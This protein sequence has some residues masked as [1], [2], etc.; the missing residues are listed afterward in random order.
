MLSQR[1]LF[2]RKHEVD[3]V[4]FRKTDITAKCARPQTSF[5]VFYRSPVCSTASL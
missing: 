4:A 1:V 3:R 5:A 2:D